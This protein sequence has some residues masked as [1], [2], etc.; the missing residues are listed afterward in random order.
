[1][2]TENIVYYILYALLVYAQ[3][4]NLLSE[5]IN[6]IQKST[7]ALLNE[8]QEV[9]REAKAEKSEYMFMSHHQNVGQNNNME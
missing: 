7:A 4:I 3:D 1:V 2:H 5:S 8:S 6:T 9:D